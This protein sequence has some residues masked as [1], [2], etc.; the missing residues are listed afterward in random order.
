VARE[1]GLEPLA[2][3]ILA[4]QTISGTPLGVAA[5]Y[6]NEQVPTAEDALA[7]ARSVGR[8]VVVGL[9]GGLSF[10]R[11]IHYV[12]NQGGYMDNALAGARQ[13]LAIDPQA[14]RLLLLSAD[15]PAV[16][17]AHIDWV[18]AQALATDEDFYY[19]VIER[20]VMEERF[21]GSRRTFLRFQ[22][23]QYCGGDVVVIRTSLFAM[24]TGIWQ[25]LSD[26]RK[27]PLKT[28]AIIGP[29][30]LLRFALGLLPIDDAVR[31]ASRRLG[32]RGRALPSPYA[33]VG[34]DVDK[35]FQLELVEEAL[36]RRGPP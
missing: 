11:E 27:S 20:R 14:V 2:A 5:R 10:P 34:M 30:V 7:G 29:W 15:I 3:L 23:R 1:R 18:V 12:P 24:D 26:A 33:E 19:S 28:A 22:G 16:L 13:L 9:D 31:L 32:V 21:P 36:R 35:P 6:I 4:Q 8:V 17:P 25:R